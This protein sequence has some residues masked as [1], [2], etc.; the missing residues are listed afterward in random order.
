MVRVVSLLLLAALV[1]GC[2]Q[3]Q[4]PPPV[5]ATATP[6]NLADTIDPRP[7]DQ[8]QAGD[9]PQHMPSLIGGP[10]PGPTRQVVTPP[11]V[12]T[13]P[14]IQVALILD[15]SKSMDGLLKQAQTRLWN[16]VSETAEIRYQGEQP[17]LEVALYEYGSNRRLPSSTGYIRKVL[18]FTTDFDAVSEELFKLS[19]EG[20]LENAPWAVET[21]AAELDWSQDPQDLKAIFIAGN[22]VFDQGPVYAEDAL[23]KAR[24]RGIAVNTIFCG[25]RTEGEQLGWAS[26]AEDAQGGYAA[27]QQDQVVAV[28]A[29]QDEEIARLNEELNS[30][31]IPYGE[32]G[33]RF[34]ARQR[35][36]DEAAAESSALA[37]RAGA[38][39]KSAYNNADW[40]VV[41]AA[42]AGKDLPAAAYPKALRGL[43][44]KERQA[45]VEETGRRRAQLQQR[46]ND[47]VEERK[48]HVAAPVPSLDEAMVESIHKQ[49]RAK[50]YSVK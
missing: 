48:A 35:A 10:K 45:R 37:L 40:D 21:A 3:P 46:I 12:R 9:Q 16:V 43:S 28:T 47:L 19:C 2:S 30:T 14:V 49:A 34:Q 31:Y 18:P 41:D 44:D 25:S 6:V 33:A 17:Q 26:I 29:P 22:E 27:I 32:D 13:G 11:R 23:E 24:S 20:G 39:A 38:K 50:G 42:R 36:Q 7:P 15:T 4:A 1:A 5:V 8:V